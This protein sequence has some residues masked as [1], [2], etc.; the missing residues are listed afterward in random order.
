MKLDTRQIR[1]FLGDEEGEMDELM[2]PRDRPGF[3]YNPI[4]SFHARQ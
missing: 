1:F 4:V 2:S 3:S